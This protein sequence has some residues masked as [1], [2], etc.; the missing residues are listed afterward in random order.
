MDCKLEKKEDWKGEKVDVIGE[1]Y[2]PG[3]PKGKLAWKNKVESRAEYIEF[4]KQSE[5]YWYS[6]SDD[7]FGSEKRKN[8]A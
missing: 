5:R 1:C 2:E 8:P 3:L 6:K 7:W 4:L